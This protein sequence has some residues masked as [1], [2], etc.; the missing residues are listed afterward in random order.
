MFFFFSFLSD[1]GDSWLCEECHGRY[2]ANF[3]LI[4]VYFKLLLIKSTHRIIIF[5]IIFFSIWTQCLSQCRCYNR[6]YQQKLFTREK[7]VTVES[8]A[9]RGSFLLALGCLQGQKLACHVQHVPTVDS[10]CPSS[11]GQL[12]SV[13]VAFFSLIIT[14][15]VLPILASSHSVL[16]SF[17]CCSW[18]RFCE[19]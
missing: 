6:P 16:F 8:K 4:F 15:F 11:L 2:A 7:I 18:Q 9:Q 13:G 19:V 1:P 5:I 12:C 3:I 14:S 17:L 10:N